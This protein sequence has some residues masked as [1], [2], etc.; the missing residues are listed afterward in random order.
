MHNLVHFQYVFFLCL[1]KCNVKRKL[2][3]KFVF[4]NIFDTGTHSIWQH[5]TFVNLK[6]TQLVL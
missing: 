5:N 4:S 1:R 2:N 3:V 6:H